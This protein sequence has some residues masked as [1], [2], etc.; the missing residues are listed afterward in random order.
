MECRGPH[1]PARLPGV[2]RLLK[3]QL[4]W[5]DLLGQWRDDTLLVVLPET[6]AEVLDEVAARN[7]LGDFDRALQLIDNFDS[8]AFG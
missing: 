6:G 2:A 1:G 3:E 4:R 8:P 7:P 5:V